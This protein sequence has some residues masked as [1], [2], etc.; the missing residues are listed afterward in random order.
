MMSETK[1]TEILDRTDAKSLSTTSTTTPEQAH[2]NFAET[3]LERALTEKSQ[4]LDQPNATKIVT[5]LDWTGPDDPEDPENWSSG[6]KAFHIIYVGLQG[7]VMYV[8]FLSSVA[9]QY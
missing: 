2:H 1:E 6:K 9:A 7:F 4:H 8:L 3:D 5:A